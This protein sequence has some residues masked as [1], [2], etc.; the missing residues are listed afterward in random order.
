MEGGGWK[1]NCRATKG[2]K[3]KEGEGGQ[4]AALWKKHSAE[5]ASGSRQRCL[6][7]A[8]VGAKTEELMLFAWS[9]AGLS[10]L[11][12]S[13]KLF[14]PAAIDSMPGLVAA[15]D[16]VQPRVRTWQ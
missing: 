4:S 12:N 6:K 14:I 7:F 3:R 9:V 16:A 1:K 11:P 15:R 8:P 5:S 10:Q 2:H 13:A